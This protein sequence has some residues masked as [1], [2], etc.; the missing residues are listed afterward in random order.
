[1]RGIRCNRNAGVHR[2]I[3]PNNYLLALLDVYSKRSP[4]LH[5]KHNV[6]D[7]ARCATMLGG[8]RRSV[9]GDARWAT[10]LGG[11]R[12]SVGDDARWAAMLGG[13]RSSVCDDAR[14][15]TTMLATMLGVRPCL[16]CDDVRWATMFGGRRCSVGDDAR[17]ARCG[18]RC[19][20]RGGECHS[21]KNATL[22]ENDA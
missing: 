12:C 14:W 10:M 18:S 1:M 13:R 20:E 6:C 22:Y 9:G 16:E 8:R 4:R 3:N 7:D 17:Y 2:V 5:S 11:Q 21:G 15:V 19:V